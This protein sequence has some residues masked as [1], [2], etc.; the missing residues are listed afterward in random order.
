VC[1]CWSALVNVFLHE[2][3]TPSQAQYDLVHACRLLIRDS[4]ITWLVHHV[5]GHQDDH[6]TYQD[7][8]RW[9]QLNVDM[10]SLA[11]QHW[12]S[13]YDD[14]RAYFSLPPTTEWSLWH[15]HHRLTSWSENSGLEHI[16]QKPSQSYWI[17]KQRIPPTATDP[18][19]TTTYNAFH[20]TV[21]PNR[22]WLTKWLTG[23]LPTGSKLLQWKATTNNLCP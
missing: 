3:D 7:L 9:G 1:D 12:K 22:L 14:Q 15:N 19:W 17:K 4:P 20:N 21:S 6:K 11:K 18:H 2:Y 8:D 5:Y 13:I 23:W 16:Y 10:D